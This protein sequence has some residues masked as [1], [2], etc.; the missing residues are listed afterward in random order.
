MDIPRFTDR[1]PH[2]TSTH[3]A[4]YIP[5][6][7]VPFS[8]FLCNILHP[9]FH[10]PH[11]KLNYYISYISCIPHSTSHT[12]Y[13]SHILYSHHTSRYPCH[14]SCVSNISH[15]ASHRHNFQARNFISWEICGLASAFCEANEISN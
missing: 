14:I 15:C 1:I 11:R 9:A 8:L 12:F 7:I 3:L 13:I 6:L 5:R 10:I 2:S 4:S